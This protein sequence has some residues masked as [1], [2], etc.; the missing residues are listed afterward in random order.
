MAYQVVIC[1]RL[2]V[3]SS[4]EQGG[5]LLQGTC[6]KRKDA[7][8]RSGDRSDVKTRPDR[9]NKVYMV[10][11]CRHDGL[12]LPSGLVGSAGLKT[13]LRLLCLVVNGTS[14]ACGSRAVRRRICLGQ[15]GRVYSDGFSAYT[16]EFKTLFTIIRIQA[17][18]YTGKVV[19]M[20][21][22]DGAVASGLRP[23]CLRGVFC[24]YP[25]AGLMMMLPCRNG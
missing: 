3:V 11:T 21:N 19:E 13:W 16:G 23:R 6:F 1:W 24:R 7:E 10:P 8:R 20:G 9:I 2:F 17:G 25:R 12:A 14:S 15:G 22:G 4:E 5:L 18:K